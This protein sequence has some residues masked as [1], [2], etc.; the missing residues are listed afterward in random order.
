MKY[1]LQ[2]CAHDPENGLWGDCLRTA[3][4]CVLDL[5]PED[6]PHFMDGHSFDAA[7]EDMTVTNNIREWLA[8]R[9]FQLFRVMFSGDNMDLDEILVWTHAANPGMRLLLSGGSSQ[10]AGHIVIVKDGKIEWDP[11]TGDKHCLL[12]PDAN[13]WWEIEWIAR[14][15]E[16]LANEE[17]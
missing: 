7:V 3:I 8:A 1:H 11:A 2:Q 15:P 13:G 4:A 17:R 9:C 14:P 6:V 10:G 5:E 16:L 12:G